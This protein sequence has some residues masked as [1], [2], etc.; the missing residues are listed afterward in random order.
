MADTSWEDADFEL[1]PLE[2]GYVP[3]DAKGTTVLAL[4]EHHNGSRV[5]ACLKFFD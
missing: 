1:A 4:K 2:D 3:S 5:A